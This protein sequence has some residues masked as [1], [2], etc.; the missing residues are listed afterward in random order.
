[1]GSVC[2]LGKPPSEEKLKFGWGTVSWHAIPTKVHAPH[3][4]ED[5]LEGRAP[6]TPNPLY[7]AKFD[8]RKPLPT[9]VASR[10]R[11]KRV[12]R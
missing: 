12:P 10:L 5:C 1:V 3:G 2:V 4:M 9:S 6:S 8:Q 7:V 11:V